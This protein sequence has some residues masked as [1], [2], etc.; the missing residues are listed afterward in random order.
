MAIHQV[1]VLMLARVDPLHAR[2]NEIGLR[3]GGGAAPSGLRDPD[4]STGRGPRDL[5]GGG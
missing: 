5:I 1:T 4:T 2:R 3:I